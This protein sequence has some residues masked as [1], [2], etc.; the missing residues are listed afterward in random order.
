MGSRQLCIT[1]K[2]RASFCTAW[3]GGGCRL[4]GGPVPF[5]TVAHEYSTYQLRTTNYQLP[6]PTTNVRASRMTHPWIADRTQAFDS[7]GIRKVFDLAARCRTRSTCRSA[8]PTSTCREPVQAA[9]IEA[10]QSGKNGYALTQGHARAARE[11]AGADRRR[12]RPCGPQGV[13]HVRHQRRAGAGDA[14]RWSTR[15]TR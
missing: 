3:N 15:A 7:S 9:C 11:A 12:V 14:G 6:L 8:S 13:R 10:I 4:D 1:T 5:Q 2:R